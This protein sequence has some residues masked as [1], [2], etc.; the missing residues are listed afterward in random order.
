MQHCLMVNAG[1]I[2]RR[3]R[4]NFSRIVLKN[5]AIKIYWWLTVSQVCY[6]TLTTSVW[7]LTLCHLALQAFQVMHDT[8]CLADPTTNAYC[9]LSAVQNTNPSDLYFYSLP[10]GIPLPTTATPSCSACSKSIM[11]I[12]AT[13]LQDPSQAKLLT[14]LKSAYKVSAQ[15]SAQFCGSAF[16][17]TSISP[18]ISLYGGWSTIFTGSIFALIWTILALVL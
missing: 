2:W 10:L 17:L 7:Q 3:L 16:A 9:Y 1:L 13:A 4:P 12:Y 5:W 8:A 18:A 11:G 6:K 15:I 14:G